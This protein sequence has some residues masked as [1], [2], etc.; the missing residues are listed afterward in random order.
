M[1]DSLS[2]NRASAKHRRLRSWALHGMYLALICGIVLASTLSY[3]QRVAASR[4]LAA[5][6]TLNRLGASTQNIRNVV[7]LSIAAREV[8]PESDASIGHAREQLTACFSLLRTQIHDVKLS[9]QL[10]QTVSSYL[11]SIDVQ[12]KLIHAGRF[13]EARRLD[14]DEISPELEVL[15]QEIQQAAASEEMLG[16]AAASKSQA[17]ALSAAFLLLT[18][19][20]MVGVRYRMRKQAEEALRKSELQYRLLFD[21]NP[22]PMWVSEHGTLKFLAVNEA[23]V[24][25]YGYSKQEFLAMT[26]AQIRPEE[27]IPA[28]L[29]ARARPIHGLQEAE[30]WRHLKKDGTVIHVEIVRHD[31]EFHGTPAELVA[32]HDVTMKLQSEEALRRAEEKYRTIFENAVLGIFQAS[33]DGRPLAVN[34]A[35]ARMHGYDSPEE[36]F[37]EVSNVGAQLFVDS[38]RMED[39]VR[40]VSETDV[41]TGAEIEVYRKDR[42]RKWMSVNLRAVRDPNANLKWLEGTVEDISGRKAAEER[43]HYLAYYD[44]LTGLPNRALLQDRLTKALASARR[45]K[46]KVGLI[47]IDLDRFKTIND[48]LGHSFGDLLLRDVAE[49][50]KGWARAQDTVARIGGDEFLFV[51]TALKDVS[52]AAIAAERIMDVMAPDFVIQGRS[53]TVTCSAGISMFPNNGSDSET[54]IK[55]ADAAM[56][57]AKESGRNAFRFFTA[58]MNAEVVERLTLEHSLRL[59]LDRQE[60]FLMYQPQMEISTGKVV[61][62]E[63]LLRWQ[64]PEIGLVSP[65]RFIRIAEN[66]GLI[67]PIG[68]WVLRTACLQAKAWQDRG[69]PAIPVSVNISAVQ[70]RQEGFRELIKRTLRDTDLPPHSL[71]L[72]LTESLLLSNS[73]VIFSVLRELKDMGLKLAIDDFGTGYSSLSYLRQFPVHR[74]KIDRSFIKD[75]AVDSDDAAITAAIISMAKSLNLR[76]IAEGVENDAQMAFLR[77][78]HCDEIQGYFFSKPLTADLA[79][80]M[81]LRSDVLVAEPQT[82]ESAAIPPER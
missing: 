18:T 40:A 14:F 6:L 2:D 79:T 61:G 42:S 53:F 20:T 71:E 43:V 75:V 4:S 25:H 23:A 38:R 29:R 9:D 37:A 49:R 57:C 46:E 44:A 81:L 51:L 30:L 16:G 35:L 17:E 28:L 68:E 76:T 73:D 36:F 19:V 31:L 15:Q 59:A 7:W 78:H 10:S 62:A 82:M 65:D 52:D 34:P 70:F 41:V 69:L 60:L 5:Q 66:S 22:L 47:F 45:R 55:N 56:Y 11:T 1:L 77:A 27:D 3:R 8:S 39:L 26:I 32:A 80:S 67:I 33:L 48:S 58:E 54:L 63:A 72:E 13:E 21:A 12:H 74:L 24:R 50:L 64:H